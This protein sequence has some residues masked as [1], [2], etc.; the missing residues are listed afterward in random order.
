MRKYSVLFRVALPLIFNFSRV[1]AQTLTIGTTSQEAC[2]NQEVVFYAQGGSVSSASSWNATNSS[3][4]YAVSTNGNFGS[5]HVTWSSPG[6]YA[7]YLSGASNSPYYF[8]VNGSIPS[9]SISATPSTSICS[10]TSVT[11]SASTSNTGSYPS[12]QWK[13]NGT[14]V[15]GANQYV[16]TTTGLSNGDVVTCTVT[17]QCGVSNTSSG[18]T[19]SVTSTTP[20]PQYALTA[21]SNNVLATYSTP[22]LCPGMRADFRSSAPS[23]NSAYTV[24][25]LLNGANITPGGNVSIITN[26]VNMLSFQNWNLPSGT[27]ISARVDYSGGG[28]VSNNPSTSSVATSSSLSGVTIS[29]SALQRCQGSGQTQFTAAPQITDYSWTITGGATTISSSGLANW[30]SSYSGTAYVTVM[31]SACTSVSTFVPVTVVPAP[32]TPANLNL[33]F[34][35][36]ETIEI[37]PDRPSGEIFNW[38]D[39]DNNLLT[40]SVGYSKNPSLLT[41]NFQ[42]KFESV[43][44]N[45]CKSIALANANVTISDDCDDK[46]NWIETLTYDDAG[47]VGSSRAYFDLAGKPL[48]SQSKNFGTNS[49]VK[50]I[51][52]NPALKDK[53]GRDAV[54]LMP[55]PVDQTDFKY[56]F[57][58]ATDG[59]GDTFDFNDFDGT[60]ITLGKTTPGTVGWYYSENNTLEQNVPKSEFAYGRQTY[61]PDGTSGAMKSGGPSDKLRIGSGH[62]PLSGSFPVANELDYYLQLRNSIV[63]TSSVT[64]LAGSS[65]QTIVRDENGRYAL[66]IADKS[67]KTILTARKG[68]S[69]DNVITFNNSLTA[70]ANDAT[71]PN[72]RQQVYFYILD[73]QPVGISGT[74]IYSVEELMSGTVFAVPSNNGNWP[75][76]FYRI[77]LTSGQIQVTYKN[78]FLDVACQFY[79]DV[80]RL[81]SSVSPN[82][83]K[84]IIS[85]TNLT[86]DYAGAD[87]TTYQYNYRGWLLNMTEPDAGTTQYLYRND[88]SIRYSQNAKQTTT[89]AFSYT[90]YDGV[91]RPVE[92]GE[93][94]GVTG[95][96]SSLKSSLEFVAQTTF[97][98]TKDWVKTY[99]DLADPNF[100]STTGLT[101]TAFP[102]NYVRNAVSWTENTNMSTWYSYDERGRVTW[103]VQKPKA[104]NRVF[105]VKYAYDFLG[106]VLTVEQ[107]SYMGGSKL[108]ALTFFHHYEYDA[109]KR[110][111]K[112]YTSTDG[113]NK[114]LHANYKYYLHG[115]LK[116]IELGG[117]LQGIDFV[118]NINGWLE[119][120]N[121]PDP[122][123]DP[124]Q[125]GQGSSTF[126][127]DVFSLLLDYYD[128]EFL[129]LFPTVGFNM[130]SLDRFHRLPGNMK[131][132]PQYASLSYL[133]A[134]PPSFFE[135]PAE[136][137]YFKNFSAQ[138]GIYKE[139]I[140][141]LKEN[142][143][144]HQN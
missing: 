122:T 83:F 139:L 3:Q 57:G 143:A 107:N 70:Q 8:T 105:V 90:L 74:G 82:G 31:A 73:A 129:N 37:N 43:G 13:V 9:I 15:A 7:V 88:G 25:W 75:A 51:V 22:F 78:Y 50:I 120:I 125:D 17:T 99:Y 60:N 56:K 28:C 4:A 76:G 45:G 81:V 42:L 131:N 130:K 26:G 63:T 72:Y 10:G 12:F 116:R 97:T 52:S 19:M 38:Y 46:L 123:R 11:F 134:M 117:N 54:S 39:T 85:G 1:L 137:L 87:K 121:H 80:G 48:Q 71:Q 84:K 59:G 108:D 53:Y 101:V 127:K 44:A 68:T 132:D 67:G 109:N 29:P 27:V 102:Q 33:A 47:L 140:G 119:S 94:A 62:E 21:F 135:Q 115:P 64:T 20:L 91:N 95:G 14:S 55:V 58:I 110:L 103:M 96:F 118:Y 141:K 34:C 49:S 30:S 113:N 16:Y 138:N 112:A 41:S 32:Q 69:S 61:Y 24:T 133:P 86:S 66:S 79:N 23:G 6:T 126:R 142:N 77:L 92:S 111:S 114:T 2:P 36:W 35:N 18:I 136:N 128:S 89:G 5:Y 106:N 40:Q 98:N 93:C 100:T 144:T 124:G 104:L 65:V